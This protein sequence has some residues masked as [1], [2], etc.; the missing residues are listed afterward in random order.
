MYPR[1]N[2]EMSDKQLSALMEA[3]KPVACMMVGGSTP[4]SPQENANRAWSTLGLELGFDSSTVQ[5]IPGLGI[6]FFSAIPSETEEQREERLAK[7]EAKKDSDELIKLEE[8]VATTNN[9]I[10]ELKQK[11]GHKPLPVN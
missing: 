8:L 4:S 9:R 11:A 7:E 2:Y 3:C 6:K 10:S 1:T 5:P